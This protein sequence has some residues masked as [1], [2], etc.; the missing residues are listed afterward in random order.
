MTDLHLISERPP[1]AMAPWNELNPRLLAAVHESARELHR[2]GLIGKRRMAR[3]DALC[4]PPPPGDEAAP[5]EAQPPCPQKE[6][7]LGRSGERRI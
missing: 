1:P 7:P 2:A 5:I 4:L 3:Y 6:I